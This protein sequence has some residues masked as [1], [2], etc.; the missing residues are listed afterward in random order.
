M[1]EH[2]LAVIELYHCNH[3]LVQNLPK[4]PPID[5]F[6]SNGKWKYVSNS[7]SI[8]FSCLEERK[9]I[10]FRTWEHPNQSPRPVVRFEY[11]IV[12]PGFLRSCF[13]MNLFLSV[14]GASILGNCNVIIKPEETWS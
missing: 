7:C 14:A 11:K 9:W 1:N 5:T 4:V 6:K 12:L 13:N 8:Q 3:A 2:Q 10:H